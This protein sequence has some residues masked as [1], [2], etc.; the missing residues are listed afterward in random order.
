MVLQVEDSLRQ[1]IF[2]AVFQPGTDLLKC[3]TREKHPRGHKYVDTV[4]HDPALKISSLPE[5]LMR[6]LIP[7]VNPRSIGE[8]RR[9]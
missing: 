2:V 8:E 9:Q 6:C 5:C 7:R 4:C 1:A 3:G